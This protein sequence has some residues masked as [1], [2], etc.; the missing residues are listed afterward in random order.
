F[1]QDG[2]TPAKGKS[3]VTLKDDVVRHIDHICQLAGDA[4]HVGIGTDFDGGFGAEAIPAELDSVADL[5]KIG[6][7]LAGAGYTPANVELVLGGNWLRLLK[8]SLPR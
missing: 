1:L 8:G 2:W 3:A 7:A 4:R 6:D 5:G